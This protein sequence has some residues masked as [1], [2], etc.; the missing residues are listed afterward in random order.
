MDSFEGKVAIVTGGGNGIGE[1]YARELGNV[2]AAVV[3]ADT[4][5]LAAKN[6]ARQLSDGGA[7]ALPLEVDVADEQQVA[8]MVEAVVREFGRVDILVNNAALHLMEYAAGCM[9]LPLLKWRRM[10][11]VNLTG[12]FLC[13]RECARIM[14]QDGNGGVIINQSS[15]AAYMGAGAYSVSKLALNG[16]TIA[17]AA[18]LGPLGIRVNGIAPGLVDSPAAMS[19]LP[20]EVKAMVHSRQILQRQ[21]K[22]EDLVGTLLLLCSEQSS[23]ITGQTILVDGGFTR[24]V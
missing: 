8:D 6:V 15:M 14:G 20:D 22:M 24:R 3:I 11:D 19:S 1:V 17:L 23:F 21:G 7:A 12:P 9:N 10:L 5:P 4:D 16:L 2:G 18:E 13:A